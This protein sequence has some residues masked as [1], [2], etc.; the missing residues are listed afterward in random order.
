[1]F[2]SQTFRNVQLFLLSGRRC[3][4]NQSGRVESQPVRSTREG[5]SRTAKNAA[6]LRVW[7][8]CSRFRVKEPRSPS[9]DAPESDMAS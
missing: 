7:I 4:A 6:S 1:M 3:W 8:G 5:R 2:C 9:A